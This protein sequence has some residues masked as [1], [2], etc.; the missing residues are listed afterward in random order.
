M[1]ISS[2]KHWLDYIEDMIDYSNMESQLSKYYNFI[3]NEK[4]TAQE[5]KENS[6]LLKLYFEIFKHSLNIY[7]NKDKKI[8]ILYLKEHN[9]I[10]LDE[11]SFFTKFQIN[12]LNHKI[13]KKVL[14]TDLNKELFVLQMKEWIKISINNYL[15]KIKTSFVLNSN[16]FEYY[17]KNYWLIDFTPKEILIDYINN[18]KTNNSYNKNTTLIYRIRKALSGY[19]VYCYNYEFF[20][21]NSKKTADT[22]LLSMNDIDISLLKKVGEKCESIF[23]GFR[24]IHYEF[25]KQVKSA[26]L[27]L[28]MKYNI[29]TVN[30]LNSIDSEILSDILLHSTVPSDIYNI[31]N[32]YQKIDI[33][34]KVTHCCYPPLLTSP[35]NISLIYNTP[36]AVIDINLFIKVLFNVNK[37]YIKPNKYKPG[38]FDEDFINLKNSLL[39]N[40]DKLS[41]NLNID[42]EKIVT[43]IENNLIYLEEN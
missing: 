13:V 28:L 39:E 27:Y 8:S 43:K 22:I 32:E 16:L 1:A 24:Y 33:K 15:V 34:C 26:Q 4:N 21:K 17:K 41:S 11:D 23:S 5:L 35:K 25:I 9:G 3:Y 2:K 30:E 36:F 7:I 19:E 10:N 38:S 18:F 12:L 14:F 31:I 20:D 40:L 6:E 29:L 42:K 37:I